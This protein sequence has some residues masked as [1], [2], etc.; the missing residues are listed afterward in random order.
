MTVAVC[1][2]CGA[3]KHGALTPCAECQFDPEENE[4]KAKAM[5]LTD[6]LLPLRELETISNRIKTGEPV[7]YPKETIDEYIKTFEDNPGIDKFPLSV[8][9]GWIAAAIAGLVL[10]VWAILRNT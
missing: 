4:D 3:M 10:V 5:V 7:T 9:M 1:I 8:K 6:H 2:R